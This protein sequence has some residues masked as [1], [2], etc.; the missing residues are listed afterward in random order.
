MFNPF[1][2]KNKI[3]VSDI[4]LVI[5]DFKLYGKPLS[6]F[7]EQKEICDDTLNISL[8]IHKDAD[9]HAIESVYNDL[10]ARL[11]LLGVAEVN[12]NVVLSDKVA[13]PQNTPD[14]GKSVQTFTPIPS[15][16]DEPTPTKSAP[17]QSDIPPHPRIRHIIVVASGKGGVGKSTT[18]V[19]IALALQKLGKK[20][21]ILDADI[22]GPSVPDMLGI[23]GVK[24]TVENDQFI[25]IE[26][27]SLA[28]LSIG[29]LIESENT[30]VAWRG[31]K[32]TGALMQLY[33]QTNWPTLD[34]LVIDMPPG[35]GDISLTLAQRIPV[36]GAIIVTTPQH[37]ALLDAQKGM[38]MFLKTDIPIIGVVENMALHTCTN[39]GH[40]EAIFGADGGV[41]LA[42]KY[43]VPLLGQLPLAST[44]RENMDKGKPSVLINDEFSAFYEGI[45]TNIEKHIAKFDKGSSGRIF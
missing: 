16:K 25:P 31:I 3:H 18:T 38:E 12:F 42:E 29:N 33:S 14:N 45:A 11:H 27:H 17:K 41:N 21:G 30:P 28:V 9:Q 5:A 34:Y 37:V 15:T 43:Q 19:N 22:Y 23:A 44:I 39:C 35:T 7:I 1:K 24:P 8:K 36:T 4:D 2:K 32:A 13:P 6:T 26:A 40:V 20:V 10:R